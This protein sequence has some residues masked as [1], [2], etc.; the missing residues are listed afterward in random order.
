M[1]RG[2]DEKDRFSDEPVWPLGNRRESWEAA[3]SIAF[4]SVADR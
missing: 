4:I 1:T 2:D 3:G